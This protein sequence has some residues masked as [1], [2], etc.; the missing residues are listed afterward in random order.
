MIV[1]VGNPNCGKS[2]LFNKLTNSNIKVG[3]YPGITVDIKSSYINNKEVVDL[4]GI[5]SLNSYS[6][7]ENITREFLELEQ[8]EL[9]IN[10]IDINNLNRSLYLTLQLLKLNTKV[11]IVLNKADLN[12]KTN[13]NVDRLSKILNTDVLKVSVK[14]NINITN[15]KDYINK[16]R[17]KKKINIKSSVNE[18]E[19]SNIYNKIDNICSKV[20]INSNKKIFILNKYVLLISSIFVLLFI[21]IVGIN[22]IGNNIVNMIDYILNIIKNNLLNI[23]NTTNISLIFRGLLI[24][25]IYTG[26]SSIL[27]FI[28]QI[29]ILIFIMSIIE[30]SGYIAY[31]SL[32]Y[33]KLLNKI[34]LSG[35]SFMPFL[36]STNCSVLGIL[37]TR[38]IK[39][40]K[41]RLKT[42]F[43]IPFIPCSAK[44]SLIIYITLI[45][46]KGSFLIFISFYILAIISIIILSFLFEKS[47]NTYI[48]ELPKLKI[49]S[50]KIAMKNTYYKTKS[51]I[52]KISTV[53]LFISIINFI[54]L[55]F[56]FKLNYN[57]D[58]KD[59]ILYQILN[60]VSYITKPI[61]GIK[62]PKA[63]FSILNG[64]IA[65]EQVISTIS[66]LKLKLNKISAYTFCLFNILSIPCINTI[67]AL[68][69]EIG[70]NFIKYII[71]YFVY[72]LIISSLLFRLL[73]FLV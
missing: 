71:I 3:N 31:L 51:F 56:D 40:K 50:I 46:F 15:I 68:K 24:D 44:M 62:D 10:V 25:G 20:I 1:L 54:L 6:K 21:Y 39:D 16:N 11:I 18:N 28:P 53:I 32:I 26:I 29:L 55:S 73:I 5:Y 35:K 34:G 65:K 9:I 67:T 45:Y 14:D 12:N 49:P 7:E 72:A 19:I 58:I 64:M 27:T 61:I 69:K 52:F 22:F 23:L 60:K 41:E 47:S 66:V 42:M 63:T 48:I 38:T 57:V 36:M 70:I 4:P 37:A 17:Y 33:N 43:L 2:A 13:I 30:D 8:I 59:S